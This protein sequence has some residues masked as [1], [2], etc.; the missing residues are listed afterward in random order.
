LS[1]LIGQ[2][3]PN[4][5]ACLLLADGCAIHGITAWG[6]VID[7][8]GDHVAAAQFAVDCQIEESASCPRS[9]ASF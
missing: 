7:A 3:E 1:R 8:N 4:G 9:A 2:L 6:D 5:P